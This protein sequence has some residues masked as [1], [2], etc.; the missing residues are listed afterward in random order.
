MPKLGIQR[1]YKLK[2]KKIIEQKTENKIKYIGEKWYRSLDLE[3][4][5]KVKISNTKNKIKI[6]YTC[7]LKNQKTRI[8]LFPCEIY[9]FIRSL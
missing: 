8:F 9:E 1:F 6:I 4:R 2:K 7:L 3:E 5:K